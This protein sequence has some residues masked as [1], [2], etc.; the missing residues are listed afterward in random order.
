MHADECKCA[1]IR[2]PRFR[3]LRDIRLRLPEVPRGA[4]AVGGDD[5]DAT[6]SGV[7]EDADRNLRS[8]RRPRSSDIRE[9]TG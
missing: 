8:I 7:I 6:V 9:L 5:R 2:R 3:F 1:A 4:A